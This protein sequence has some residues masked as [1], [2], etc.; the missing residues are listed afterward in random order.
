MGAVI[1]PWSYRNYRTSGHFVLVTTGTGDAFLR[2]YFFSKPEYALLRLPPYTYAENECNVEFER[3]C[4]EAGTECSRDDIETDKILSRAAKE[5]FLSDPAG[6]LRKFAVQLFTFWYEMTNVVNSAVA[7][8]TALVLWALAIAG[9]ARA[10]LRGLPIWPPLLLILSINVPLA[11]LLALGRYS[12][13]VAPALTIMA[14][15]GADL[16]WESWRGAGR[17]KGTHDS[18][19]A[20]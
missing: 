5:K 11:A 17:A 3:L 7:G 9:W 1:L 19:L 4:R 15:L 14:G 2:G 10:R 12:V 13:P 20:V 16:L 18:S 8:C 6:F